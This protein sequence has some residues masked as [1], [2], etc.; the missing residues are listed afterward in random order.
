M[1]VKL[2][3]V[4]AGLTIAAL[5]ANAGTFNIEIDFIGAGETV[6]F[7]GG[8]TETTVA[9]TQ[10]QKDAFE[11]AAL[12]WENIITGYQGSFSLAEYKI[13]AAL[14]PEDGQNGSLAYASVNGFA[15][16][17]GFTYGTSGFMAFDSDDWEGQTQSVAGPS[18]QPFSTFIGSA[19]HEMAHALGFGS[20]WY[21]TEND[22]LDPTA[23]QYL[24]A[25]ALN[26]YKAEF[27]PTATFIPT[28][29][30]THWA[31]CAFS[32]NPSCDDAT[33]NDSELMTP[34]A[35][36]QDYLSDTT[37]AQFRDLGYTTRPILTDP[38]VNPV[39]LPAAAW[40]MLAGLGGLGIVGRRR[41]RA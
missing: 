33:Y 26:A 16:S 35:V 29:G 22:L 40:L 38:V 39:P 5:P 30:D 4:L 8:A 27:D 3:S 18:G 10:D 24:G 1:K 6:N 37:V 20:L 13:T 34:L 32:S 23:K 15:D 12:F 9:F 28:D 7:N 21:P 19:R 14:A 36:V 2:C 11:D 41:S 25:N 31:E 17:G